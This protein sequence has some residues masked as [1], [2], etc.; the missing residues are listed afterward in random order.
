M[1]PQP[2]PDMIAVDAEIATRA[3]FWYKDPVYTEQDY[4]SGV[5]QMVLP[6]KHDP[7]ISYD[8]LNLKGY[9]DTSEDTV[10]WEQ[11]YEWFQENTCSD[12]AKQD[13]NGE[14]FGGPWQEE[15]SNP[16]RYKNAWDI[17]QEANAR[18]LYALIP[19]YPL[20]LIKKTMH[21]GCQ[22]CAIHR[23]LV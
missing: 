6:F 13:A 14:C 5:K 21:I 17:C 3:P 10:S 11:F 8:T 19:A 20:K 22:I 7:E 1:Q 9:W 16:E 4:T 15:K 23:V 12:W 2:S 18:A